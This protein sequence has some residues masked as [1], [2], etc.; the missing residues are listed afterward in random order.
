MS[1]TFHELKELI[2]RQYDPDDIV[3]ILG[4]S[5]EELLDSFEEKVIQYQH[6]FDIDEEDKDYEY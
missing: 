5:S 3:D 4:L 1:R 6:R 2:I